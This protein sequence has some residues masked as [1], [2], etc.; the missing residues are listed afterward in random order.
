MKIWG[1]G[2]LKNSFKEKKGK[3][4]SRFLFLRKLFQKTSM[5]LIKNWC[6]PSCLFIFK[7]H[8]TQAGW[9]FLLL[10]CIQVCLFINLLS[11][12]WPPD[13]AKNYRPQIWYKNSPW[14]YLKTIFRFF[15]KKNYCR[16]SRGFSAHLVFYYFPENLFLLVGYVFLPP[17]PPDQTE[18]VKACISDLWSDELQSNIFG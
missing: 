3:T 7:I 12:L 9:V 1:E 18:S 15:S 5:L 4:V 2:K 6:S 14:A 8:V 10:A 13:R 11:C 16:V 17:P